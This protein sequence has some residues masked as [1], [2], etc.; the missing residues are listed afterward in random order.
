MKKII[1]SLF[2]CLM[3]LSVSLTNIYANSAQTR[4]SGTDSTGAIVLEEDS[5][6]IVEKELLTFDIQEFP[7]SYYHNI[8]DF[9]AYSAKVT[10]EYTFYNPSDYTVTAT[11]AFPFGGVADY[12]EFYDYINDRFVSDVDTS[13][14]DVTVDGEVITK[15][16]RH[17]LLYFGDQFELEK[18]VARLH[19]SYLV[20]EFYYPEQSVTKYTYKANGVDLETYNAASASIVLT[21]DN[22]N[23]KYFMVNQ[24]GYTSR[25][26]YVLMSTW[27]EK[28]KEYVIYVIGEPLEENLEW[29][30]YENGACKDE[31]DGE[32]EL[33]EVQNMTLK[34]FVLSEY[35][36][37][38]GVIDYDWYNAIITMFK[39]S[40]ADFGT[41]HSMDVYMNPSNILMRWYQ[42]EIT[43]EPKQR[44][45]NTVTAPMY[46]AINSRYEPAIYNYTYLLSPAKT[47]SE[48]GNLDIIL[49]TPYSMTQCSLVGFEDSNYGYELHLAGLPEGELTFT[50]SES[51]NPKA[52]INRNYLV[53]TILNL[54]VPA[55]IVWFVVF[56]RK[57]K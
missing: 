41:I 32:M 40:E 1:I 54:V 45:V 27:M 52:P 16:L 30:I 53:E 21:E 24:N 14:Y 15:Q 17:T 11:L 34:E 46:P 55:L 5:P 3:T 49:N 31:I 51:A 43:L 23:R 38:Y 10:A 19:D 18:D 36:E 47:W 20:D 6:I 56:R 57:R 13:K 12:A 8:S 28:E 7:Q 44:I 50:L 2:V 26:D 35:R 39:Y 4:W 9:Q 25:S 48:F 37:E 42:Y 33:L 29:K 22:A